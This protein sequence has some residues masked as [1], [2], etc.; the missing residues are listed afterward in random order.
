MSSDRSAIKIPPGARARFEVQVRAPS[1][2][3]LEDD[4][5]HILTTG[6][7]LSTNLGDVMPIFAVVEALQGQL[8]AS[9]VQPLHFRDRDGEFSPSRLQ[10]TKRN[11]M[12]VPLDLTWNSRDDSKQPSNLD[13]ITIP[14]ANFTTPLSSNETR[15]DNIGR[16][17]FSHGV[18]LYLKSS[19]SR[20]VRLLNVESCNPWFKFVPLGRNES[21][22]SSFHDGIIAGSIHT[23]VDCSW[24]H[25]T[26]SGF[27]SFYQCMLN[28]LS[29]RLKLQPEGCGLKDSNLKLRQIDSVKRTIEVGLRRLKKSYKIHASFNPIFGDFG[30]S[31][32]NQSDLSHIKTGRRNNDGVITDLDSYDAIWKA[33][34]IA[35]NFGYNL[36][37]S[38][39]RATVEYD[40]EALSEFD[41]LRN[42]T[43]KQNL[44]LSIHN[45]AV[46]S[47]LKAPKL[48][49]AD[50]DYLEFRP[51]VVG[52]VTS[53]VIAVR[54]PTGV[55]VRVRLG[56]APLKELNVNSL[57]E[58]PALNSHSYT[59]IEKLH[60]IE[61]LHHPYVQNGRSSVP[62]NDSMSFLWWDGSGGYFIP[63]EQGDIIRSHHNISIIR[64]GG[65]TSVSMINPSL[66]SQVGF[67]VGCG[68]RC[69][70]RDKNYI[71][72]AIDHPV[73]KS[74]IGASA[75]SGITL[76][77]YV[78]YSSPETNDKVGA[79][80][81]ILAGGTSIPDTGGPSAFAI[82]FPALDEIVIPPFGK[83]QLGPIYFRPTGRYK[84]IGC[85]VARKSGTRLYGEKEILCNSQA[86]DS[87]IYLENSLTG[88]EKV[89]LRGRSLWDHL[90]FIDPPPK[91]GEDAFGDIEFRDGMP[92]LIFSGTSHSGLDMKS[93]SSL[94]GKK[95]QRTSVTKEIVLYNGGDAD[96]EVAGVYILGMN[97]DREEQGS[98]S[99]G[100]FKLLNCWDS[101]SSSTSNIRNGFV[102][103]P[104]ESRSFFVE[105]LPDCTTKKEFVTL[106]VKLNDASSPDETTSTLHGGRHSRSR[107]VQNP[108]LNKDTSMFFGYQMN[109]ATFARCMP[110]DARLNSAL[111][112][113]DLKAINPAN[114]SSRIEM[115]AFGG[116]Q[117]ESPLLIFQVVLFSTAA[118]LLCY[119]LRAR[120]HAILDMLQKTEGV[121]P[122]NFRSN[123]NAAFRCLARSDPTSTELQTMSREQIRQVVLGRYKAKGNTTSSSSNSVNGFSRDRRA[124]TSN[125]PRQRAGK[126][127][128]AGNERIRP[129]SDAIFHDTSVADESSLRIH[130]PVG[131][132][133]R[134]AYSRG[135]IKDNSLQS[136][137]FYSRTK[138]LLDH[139]AS[140]ALEND[141]KNYT[142]MEMSEKKGLVKTNCIEEK[143]E[144]KPRTCLPR[145]GENGNKNEMTKGEN[146]EAACVIS[147]SEYEETDA[148]KPESCYQTYDVERTTDRSN[149]ASPAIEIVSSAR[150][151]EFIPAIP[152]QL[153]RKHLS[154]MEK[155]NNGK[156]ETPVQYNK[157]VNT[158]EIS[159]R[160]QKPKNQIPKIN[161]QQAAN[162]LEIFSKSAPWGNKQKEKVA[163]KD[164]SDL[165]GPSPKLTSSNPWQGD[166]QKID[167]KA[168]VKKQIGIAEKKSKS[169]SKSNKK[170]EKLTMSGKKVDPD[171]AKKG[172]NT[173]KMS[174][175][176]EVFVNRSQPTLITPPPGF[177]RTQISIPLSPTTNTHLRITSSTESKLS[178]ETML[179]SALTGGSIDADTSVGA[180]SQAQPITLSF[181]ENK[182]GGSD[183]LFAG[184]IRDS[185][186]SEKSSG[187]VVP[188]I[189]NDFTFQ[190]N[191]SPTTTRGFRTIDVAA[192]AENISALAPSVKQPWL[193]ALL[194]EEPEPIEQPWLPALLNEDAES[195]F[196]VMDFLDGILQDGSTTSQDEPVNELT[197]AAPRTP[198]R[199]LG[200]T[201]GNATTPVLANP[202]ASEGKS[203]A[204]AYGISFD[205]EENN[206]NS[207]SQSGLNGL[208]EGTS[209]NEDLSGGL[210]SNIP[211]LTPAA[212]L[213]AEENNN[214]DDKTISFYAGLLDE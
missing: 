116:D 68:T 121:P 176:A 129:F 150:E 11:I 126:E 170:V 81:I 66:Q 164:L 39:L 10:D 90:Y 167:M 73:S 70:L 203:R 44:S 178:L 26:D 7:T 61:N 141:A 102:L 82:P 51:T 169:K 183:L 101:N 58:A 48:F 182:T 209:M 109:D 59:E 140:A 193:P 78:R 108:F 118:L 54:N 38:S 212:I 206:D 194:N 84:M 135:V 41:N 204:S 143:G 80:P 19:F 105:H 4:I 144:Y 162:K 49:D 127:G 100:S 30:A 77:G 55:P 133:W 153:P 64:G 13:T 75:A 188:G 146:A 85:D 189:G 31:P 20:D 117:K 123:W 16:G 122:K 184:N 138:A 132:G 120:F 166:R 136:T 156:S 27:P 63:N 18:P 29:H 35:D 112:Y 125:N 92:T 124:T 103:K 50:N 42:R 175:D 190:S 152:L 205:E 62:T 171:F 23:N 95:T 79:E 57:T 28:W 46:Q 139:R 45:L 106:L 110:A 115:K 47:V 9:Q 98:C 161:E 211:L 97:S 1:Q 86:F 186:L 2:E 165:L 195:G 34:K 72:A 33:L 157:S 201:T 53:A 21:F 67:L 74:P 172:G 22:E 149:E 187:N 37:S 36:L 93:K 56:T 14:P 142:V 104:Q 181:P 15:S 131:L 174:A 168:P 155:Q 199:I 180:P 197:P 163:P 151:V 76:T 113:K 69:G 17:N 25:L 65:S 119:A 114:Y 89:G 192:T 145:N 60:R 94:F 3:Y 128:S 96:S 196:D 202:W 130:F 200:G 159:K 12:N 5:S 147:I 8:H 213:N 207:S 24:N 137:S 52:S 43:V 198:S 179:S 148:N 111:I 87:M 91:D 173:S 214:S 107:G 6:L 158:T 210:G 160:N 185:R 40:S 71:N 134:A 191:S 88:I 177:D 99:F 208:L 83:G 154:K 32:S